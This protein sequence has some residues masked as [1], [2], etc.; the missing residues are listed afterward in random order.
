MTAPAKPNGTADFLT[1]GGEVG[2]R[3]RDFDWSKT[4]LDPVETWPQSFKTAVSIC[5]GSRY[6]IVLW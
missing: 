6:P 4:P 2:E 3:M 1:G 5:L